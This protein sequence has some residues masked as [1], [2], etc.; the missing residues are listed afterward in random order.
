M[1]IYTHALF[2]LSKE[3]KLSENITKILRGYYKN[4]K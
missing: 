4:I 3:E 2:S 1:C